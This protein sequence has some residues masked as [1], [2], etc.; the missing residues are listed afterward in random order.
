[1]AENGFERA[2]KKVSI[3]E[4]GY[5]NHPKD[6]GGATY[7][8]VIQRVYDSFRKAKGLSTRSV[9]NLTEK[10]RLEIYRTRYWDAIKGDKLP[11]GIDYVVYDG[12][13]N[14]GPI[15]SVKW[16]QRAL[17][18]NYTGKVDGLVGPETLRALDALSNHDRLVAKIC[19]LRLNFL[20]ALKTFPTFG[21]GWTNRVNDV[22]AVG[23][24]WAK[25][26]VGP[27]I[28]YVEGGDAK[29]L[30]EDAK[31]PPKKEVATATAATGASAGIVTT[32]VKSLQETIT[33]Y[34]QAGSAWIDNLVVI[35]A[36]ITA[37]LTVGGLAWRFWQARKAAELND[38]L[39]LDNKGR[40]EV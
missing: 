32:A 12:A 37:I 21:R 20:K 13:V 36:I 29:A 24:A 27:E 40:A 38:A 15:Q 34:S 25:G 19:E 31:S 14:S 23:Q 16:L 3:H 28:T 22:K 8:G 18:S 17:G 26:D 2:D 5:V 30:I 33:P 39:G 9:K 7:K 1:M 4:G 10:E 6:P 35:L 11:P